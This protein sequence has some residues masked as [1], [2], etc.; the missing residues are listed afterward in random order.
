MLL[1]P[2]WDRGSGRCRRGLRRRGRK[3]GQHALSFQS[4]CKAVA[5]VLEAPP[6]RIL[7]VA[8]SSAESAALSAAALTGCGAAVEGNFITVLSLDRV[9]EGRGATAR[10]ASGA[11]MSRRSRSLCG[12]VKSVL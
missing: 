1:P 10:R 12:A 6:G 5:V 3:C 8:T 7:Y 11:Q 2:C 9:E 4:R